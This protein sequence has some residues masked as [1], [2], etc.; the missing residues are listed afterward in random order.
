MSIEQQIDECLEQ[1][2]FEAFQEAFRQLQQKA[3]ESK[4]HERAVATIQQSVAGNTAQRILPPGFERQFKITK[5]QFIR[6]KRQFNADKA[7]TTEVNY[8]Q[9]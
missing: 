1:P 8:R 2:S 3:K 5:A 7:P 6:F 9:G 4:A